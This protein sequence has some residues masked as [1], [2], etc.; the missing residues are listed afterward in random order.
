MRF[1]TISVLILSFTFPIIRS[2]TDPL[3]NFRRHISPPKIV[4]PKIGRDKGKLYF[5]EIRLCPKSY[6]TDSA[7]LGR[8]SSRAI[9]VFESKFC[10]KHETPCLLFFTGGNSII[11]HKIYSNLLAGLSNKKVSIYTIPFHYSNVDF[12]E[13]V[14]Q[15]KT[16]Y[17]DIIAIS[18]SSGSVPLIRAV[19][20]NPDITKVVMLDPIDA[21]VNRRK[22]IHLKH[23]K[24]LFV[25]RSEKA[26]EG[27]KLPFIPRFL[28]LTKDKLNLHQECNVN[29][30]NAEEY[31]HCDLL[32]PLYANLVHK[33][34]RNICDGT[35]DRT[36]E[37]LF[38]YIDWLT[39]EI[40][41]FAKTS[42]IN[43][44]TVLQKH[45]NNPCD[46]LPYDF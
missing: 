45:T 2:F 14:K 31:G 22:R 21:R 10:V 29:I 35:V 9:H 12:I 7:G 32:D 3:L 46:E 44:L 43:D 37:N 33:Y 36:H 17:E 6:V 8:D 11:T 20:H 18:H 26:Y 42:C 5:P 15:L 28:E 41:K 13:L 1:Y 4:S 27:K 39:D 16:E 23:L 19:S 25:V 24:H 34:L 40:A 30:L 38:R